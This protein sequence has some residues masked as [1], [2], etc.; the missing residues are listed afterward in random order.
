MRFSAH[1]YNWT[2]GIIWLEILVLLP[3]KLT[4]GIRQMKLLKAILNYQQYAVIHVLEDRTRDVT[5]MVVLKTEQI[6]GHQW[7]RTQQGQ[8][9]CI[10]HLKPQVKGLNS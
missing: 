7:M 4:V 5:D 10:H 1:L 9:V 6:R 2:S 3:A 8:D